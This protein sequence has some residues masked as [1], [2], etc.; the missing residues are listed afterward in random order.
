MNR[1]TLQI[2]PSGTL[3][4]LSVD[5]A[6]GIKTSKTTLSIYRHK[7][8]FVIYALGKPIIRLPIAEIE[9]KESLTDLS[10]KNLPCYCEE[11]SQS[12]FLAMHAIKCPKCIDKNLEEVRNDE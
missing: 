3:F 1:R 8:H 4:K 12:V 11:H 6:D 2:H 9:L 10:K 5:C 7:D